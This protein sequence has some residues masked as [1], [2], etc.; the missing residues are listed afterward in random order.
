MFS[1]S[2]RVACASATVWRKAVAVL[3]CGALLALAR[4][5]AHSQESKPTGRSGDEVLVL[6]AETRLTV[7]PDGFRARL[8]APAS[9]AAE[10]PKPGGDHGKE[11]IRLRLAQDISAPWEAS[12]TRTRSRRAW[13][14]SAE[15]VVIGIKPIQ[16]AAAPSE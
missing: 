1:D 16:H 13:R 6:Q 11:G 2:R 3:A 14:R 4:G 15:V 12:A 9:K 5:T 10:A 7:E 8:P